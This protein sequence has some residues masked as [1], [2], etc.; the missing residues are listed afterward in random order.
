M[1]QQV[2]D[3]L[4]K[5]KYEIA[6]TLWI[7]IHQFL[8]KI[9]EPATFIQNGEPIAVQIAKKQINLVSLRETARELLARMGTGWVDE[10]EQQIAIHGNEFKRKKKF[11]GLV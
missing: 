6:G 2:E 10:I 9:C 7:D 3:Y 11:L 1:S 4:K 8:G 5:I